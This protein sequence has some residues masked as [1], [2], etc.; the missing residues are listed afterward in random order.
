MKTM[1]RF[2]IVAACAALLFTGMLRSAD[3]PQSSTPELPKALKQENVKWHALMYLRFK[4]DKADRGFAIFERLQ[5]AWRKSGAAP[6]LSYMMRSG[7]WNVLVI[8]EVPDGA[9]GL[10]WLVSPDDA[11]FFKA[12]ADQ[13]GGTEKGMALWGEFSG[14]LQEQAT[15]LAV[16]NQSD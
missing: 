13:E 6:A 3:A 4:S 1:I 2:L 5:K 7:K 11:K 12:L 14:C 9:R 15:E 16:V 8:F 10:D